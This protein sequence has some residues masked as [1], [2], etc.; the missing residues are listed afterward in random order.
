MYCLD[1]IE[2]RRVVTSSRRG[3]RI[4]RAFRLAGFSRGPSL[5]H[6]SCYGNSS[7]HITRWPTSTTSID[8]RRRSLRSGRP[9]WP[10]RGAWL[11]RCPASRS[12]SIDRRPPRLRPPQDSASQT[13]PN[14]A[15][16]TPPPDSTPQTPPPRFSPPDSAA[17]PTRSHTNGIVARPGWVFIE[18]ETRLHLAVYFAL[19]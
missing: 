5:T 13:A 4:Q 11:L 15:S 7:S 1:P 10:P 8:R 3:R 2:S 19:I 18:R 9:G 14:S 6:P 16:Q 17:E 12:V